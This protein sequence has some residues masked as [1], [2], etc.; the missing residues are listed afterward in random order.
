MSNNFST[1][2]S[3]QATDKFNL[4]RIEPARFANDDLTDIGGGKY[5][6]TL[7][8]FVVSQVKENNTSL[9]LVTSGPAAGEYTYNES[10]SLLTIYP[11]AAPS[12]TNA[13]IVYYYLFYTSGEDNVVTEDPEN[14]STTSRNWESRI[15]L[16]PSIQNSIKNI[17]AGVLTINGS[18]LSL[19]NDSGDLN[20]YFSENDSWFNKNIKI[21]AC[22]DSSENIQKVFEG[23]ISKVSININNIILSIVDEMANFDVPAFLGDDKSETYVTKSDYANVDPRRANKPI[24]F[25]FGTLSRYT[26]IP[27]TVTNL[28]TAEQIDPGSLY[29][30]TC[31]DYTTNL[32]TTTN[33]EW[34]A[35]RTADGALDFSCTPSNISNADANFTRLDVTAGEA[36]KFHIGD[37]FYVDHSST[38]Y[39]VRVY[40]VDRVN[41]YVYVTKEATIVTTDTIEANDMPTV[42]VSERDVA[43][44]LLYGRDYTVTETATSGSNYIYKIVLEDNFEAN[45]AGLTTINPGVN[46]VL[47]RMKPDITNAVHGNVL[48][49]L[50]ESVGLTVNSA[51]ITTAN[52]TLTSRCNFSI[53]QFD[54][55]DFKPYYR[56][57]ELL[58]GSTF[59]CIFLNN[60]FEIEYKLFDTPSSSTTLTDNDILLDSFNMNLDYQD[61]ITQ[62]IGYNFHY[63]ANEVTEMAATPSVTEV[64]NKAQYLHEIN[65]TV[66]FRHILEDMSNRLSDIMNF[67]SERLVIYNFNTVAVNLDSLIGDDLKLEKTGLLGDD[68]SRIVTLTKAEKNTNSVSISAVD[69]IGV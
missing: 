58:L 15:N 27:E 46:S 26:T 67:R 36:A 2:K 1:L 42:I 44:Y 37:T 31:I 41:N 22:I 49:K 14:S 48:K 3:N 54:E 13:I 50:I 38:N 8:G 33:R 51:S 32:S 52:T 7:S 69:F 20:A 9:S 43:Y 21:W 12:T 47:F 53:P 57:I 29:E 55:T 60:S 39:P 24:P 18:T 65:K 19:V 11:N 34:L 40:Y 59:G 5:T 56:Y 4:V 23:S 30:S 28:T 16:P 10:T 64:S 66:R 6:I 61:I 62:L 68:S 63:S 45:H 17:L 25:I 35:C